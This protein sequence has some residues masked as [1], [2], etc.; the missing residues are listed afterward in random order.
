MIAAFNDPESQYFS[1]TLYEV[2]VLAD[3]SRV[4]VILISRA[5][6]EA[7]VCKSVGHVFCAHL[8]FMAPVQLCVGSQMSLSINQ[9]VAVLHAEDGQTC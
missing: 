6:Q 4:R 2:Q 9:H 8:A 7:A 1:T 3:A 5:G